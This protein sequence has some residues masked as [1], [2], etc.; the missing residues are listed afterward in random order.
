MGLPEKVAERVAALDP[1]QQA[2]VLNF[3]EF[4]ATRGRTLPSQN[5]EWQDADFARLAASQ[6]V[7]DEDPVDYQLSNCKEVWPCPPSATSR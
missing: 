6:V 7:D 3:V 5:A 1:D 2:E 4:L